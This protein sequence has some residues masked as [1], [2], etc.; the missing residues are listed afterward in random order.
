MASLSASRVS[1][2]KLRSMRITELDR[3]IDVDL[4]RQDITIL[5]HVQDPAFDEDAGYRQQTIIDIPV[6]R[7]PGE[8]LQLQLQHFLGLIGGTLDAAAELDTILPAHAVVD[9]I[10]R[11]AAEV[12]RA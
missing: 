12:A 11:S 1:Q 3:V 4:L 2:T 10:A 8:P 7:H 6:V 5:R 9:E